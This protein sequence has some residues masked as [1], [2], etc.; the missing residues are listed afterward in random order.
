MLAFAAFAA[1]IEARSLPPRDECAADAEFARFRAQLADAV[2]RHDAPGFL[3]L[4]ADDIGFT[5]EGVIGP[6]KAEFA[7]A[8]ELAD[9][10]RSSLWDELIRVLAAGCARD[11]GRIAAPYL[12][13]RFPA[14]LDP[15]EA[16]VAG[17]G[18]RLYE[19]QD[20][21]GTRVRI[22]W[23]VLEEAHLDSETGWVTVRLSD[24][25]RGFVRREDLW[26]SIDYHAIFEKR[27]G[28]WRMTEFRGGG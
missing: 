12:Y 9:P 3:A 23:E 10:D 20:A 17:P 27:E 13:L 28:Q 16:G 19:S 24:G 14:E 11:G 5:R 2:I 26:S 21:T 22:A 4:V 25:R 15:W 6:G 18:A 7:L 1:P 8:W